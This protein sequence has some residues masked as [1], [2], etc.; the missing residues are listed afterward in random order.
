MAT[1]QIG[2][3]TLDRDR[4]GYL[5]SKLPQ[6]EGALTSSPLEIRGKVRVFVNA[7]GLGSK[8]QLRFALLDETYRPIAGYSVADSR[9]L[10]KDGLRQP[11]TWLKHEVVEGVEGQRLL[12]QVRFLGTGQQSPRLYVVYLTAS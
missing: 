4:F 12:L 9:P 1:H 6:S 10:E 5:S 11:V 7:E 2:L 3:A 8:S